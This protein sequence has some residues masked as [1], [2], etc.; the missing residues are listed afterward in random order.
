MTKTF[1]KYRNSKSPSAETIEEWIRLY[2]QDHKSFDYIAKKYQTAYKIVKKYFD[3]NG[4]ESRSSGGYRPWPEKTVYWNWRLTEQTGHGGYWICTCLCGSGKTCR[5]TFAQLKAGRSK[6]CGC[7][8]A[9]QFYNNSY[10]PDHILNTCF[11]NAKKRGLEFSVTP[12]YLKSL[13]EKQNYKCAL[14][15][16]D[17]RLSQLSEAWSASI[18]RIDSS[19][20]YV[21]GNIQWLHAKINLLKLEFS[22]EEIIFLAKEV[23]SNAKK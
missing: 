14:S 12:E 19:K 13:I 8:Y 9:S 3:L 7:L 23:F 20:G 2:T 4:V 6:S 16:V 22:N 15:G 5:I 21:E 10:I 11:A 18:D 17:I 1:A